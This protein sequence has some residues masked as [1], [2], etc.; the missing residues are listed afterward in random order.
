MIEKQFLKA[1]PHRHFVFCIP[2][3]LRRC[4]LYDRKLLSHLS[5]CGWESLKILFQGTIA[6]RTGQEFNQ[7][8][9]RIGAFWEDRCHATAVESGEHLLK[10]LVYI[11]LNMVRTGVVEHPS[12]GAFCV[13]NEIQEPG[14]KNILINYKRFTE[15]LDFE[16]YDEVITY[17]PITYPLPTHYPNKIYK[18]E[19]PEK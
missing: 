13:Y 2:K 14:R 11:D 19:E 12:E 4:F 9:S 1:V 8:K 7:R 18:T 5:R 3:I 17:T 10:C 6:G 15:L 16:S